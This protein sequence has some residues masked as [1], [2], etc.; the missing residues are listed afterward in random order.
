MH[1]YPNKVFEDG[2]TPEDVE[3]AEGEEGDVMTELPSN[4]PR[5]PPTLPV[6]KLSR[7]L[8]VVLT[9]FDHGNKVSKCGASRFGDSRTAD[10]SLAP[11]SRKIFVY[12]HLYDIIAF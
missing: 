1:D 8:S 3:D 10:E 7:E 5:V 12:L 4:F 2:K 11:H 6:R 9:Q